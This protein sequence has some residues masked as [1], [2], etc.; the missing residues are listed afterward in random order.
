MTIYEIKRR[1]QNAPYFFTAKTL[2]YFGQTLKSFSVRKL[3]N[4]NFY[5][6][7]SSKY[8]N[9]TEREFNPITNEFL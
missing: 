2:K 9:F 4:G 8:G 6:F 7:A 3:E 5:I 1:V